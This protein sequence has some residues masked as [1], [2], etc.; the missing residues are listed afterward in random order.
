[1]IEYARQKFC[2]K[3]LTGKQDVFRAIKITIPI[4]LIL[5]RMKDVVLGLVIEYVRQKFHAKSRSGRKDAN[6]VI[7]TTKDRKKKY[8]S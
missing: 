3:N 7:K 8:C 4:L 1:M 5:I 6:Y 2:A